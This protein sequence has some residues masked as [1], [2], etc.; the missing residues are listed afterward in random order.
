[1]TASTTENLQNLLQD[2]IA[3]AKAK[4]A[5]A[6]DAMAFDSLSVSVGMRTGKTEKLERS[7]SQDFGLRVLIGKR[8]AIVSTTDRSA[9]A[10]DTLIDRAVSMAK[11]VPEDPYCGLADPDQIATELTDLDACDP[12]EPDIDHLSDLAKRA[13]D[14][15]LAVEGVTNTEGGEA[16]YSRSSIAIAASNG[17]S[18]AYDSSRHAIVASVLA[19]EGLG[20]ERDYAY[21]YKVHA[22]DMRSPEEIGRE[23][24][25][26]AVKR[27]NPG[28]SESGK[29]PVVFDPRVSS[30]ILS[31]LLSAINGAAI[32]R[33]TSFLKDKMGEQILAADISVE[34]DPSLSRGLRSRRFDAEGL[35]PQKMALI[36]DGVLQS[37]V[38]DLRA[39]RQLELESTGH[40]SRGVSG[41]PSP[42]VS[43]V[44]F[45]GAVVP[46]SELIKDIKSG[47]YVTEMMG[48]AVSIV[49]GDYSRGAAGFWIEDGVIT[50]PVSELTVAGNLGDMFKNIRLADDLELK[51]G[52]DAP[53][54]RIDGM[55]IAG[56]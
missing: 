2:V 27:L 39:A 13:E 29:L 56:S 31:H 11:N 8:Q 45:D 22:E 48:S 44:W 42:S 4:G 9:D 34:E 28:K 51:T 43:N 7:E 5:D 41:P 15:A 46:V 33:G 55:T 37:W 23:A 49:T 20:M 53:T 38:L 30:S 6:A 17:F 50:H 1:M 25:E 16:S 36:E 47:L 19:G 26:R 12:T 14:A 3:K 35:A 54:L 32:A 18:G 10:L 52:V 24:G 21:T 40:A